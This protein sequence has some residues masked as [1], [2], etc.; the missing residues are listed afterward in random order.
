[1][2]AAFISQNPKRIVL[3]AFLFAVVATGLSL[4]AFAQGGF[5]Y[6]FPGITTNNDLTIGNINSVP[7]TATINFYDTAGKLNTLAVDLGPGTQTRVNPNTVALTTFNGSVVVTSPVPLAVSADQFEGNSPFEFFYPSELSA[8]LLIPFLPG[9]TASVDVNVFNPGPNQAEVKVVLV[10]SNGQHGTSR[11]ATL[12]P[13]HTTTINVSASANVA[14]AYVTTANIL[15]PISPVAASAVIRN[16]STGTAGAPGAVQ[17]TDFAVVP[18]IPNQGFSKTTQIPFFAQGPDYFSLVQ[19]DNLSSVQQTIS[20][21][22][23]QADGTPLPG[24]NNPASIV[25]PGYGSIRQEMAQMFG[26]TATG[27]A[28]G[29]ITATSQ[30]T[31]DIHG[32]PTGG[33]PALITTAIAIGNLSEGSLAVLLP[34]TPQTNFTL[35]LRG[36]GREFFTG[37]SILNP[38]TNDAHLSLTFI[39][40]QGT[41]SSNVSLTVPRGRE[42]IG[43]LS[44]LF[45]EAVGNGYILVRS[46]VPINLVGLDG[47]SDNSALATRAPSYAATSFSPAPQQNYLIVGTVRDTS[48]GING[49][50]IG[51]PNVAF[52]LSGPIDTTT[53]T[54][55]A[56]TFLFRDLPP[57]RYTLTPLP[58]GF[59]VNPGPRTIV[60]TNTNSHVNDFAIGLIPPGI[61]TV[62][63]ASAQLVSSTPGSNPNLPV[64]VQG[65]NFIDPTTFTGNIFTGNINKFTTGSVFVFADS[66]VPTTVSSPTLLTASVPPSLLV[67][68]GTVQ[69]RVRN[70]GPSGDFADSVSVPFTIGTAPPLLT[71]VTGVPN[72][73]IAGH[74]PGQFTV[75]VNGSGFTPATRVRVNF[76]DR[77]TTYVNQNQVMGTVLPSDLTIP[78]FVPITVQ[79]P[80]TV[81]SVAY[82][83]PL[84]Y[85]IPVISKISPTSIAA[86]VTLTAQ[87]VAVT[88]TGTDFSQS[89][90]NPL[91]TAIVLVNGARVETQYISTTQV[92]GL[93]PPTVVSVPGVLQVAVMNPQPNLAA[94]NA[95]ALFVNNPIPVIT[96]ID[97]G[98]VAF[99][100]NSPPNDFFNQQV[101]V[102]GRDFSPDAVAWFNPPCDSLGLRKALATVRNS[103]TQIV[104]TIPIRCAGKFTISVANPQPGGGL[105][106]PAT[107]NVPTVGSAVTPNVIINPQLIFTPFAGPVSGTVPTTDSAPAADAAPAREEGASGTDST[108]ADKKSRPAPG[109]R[110]D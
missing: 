3:R 82:Q 52:S 77:P 56:G 66:Q 108:E 76:V 91:D 109:A 75:T 80:N 24:T 68:T 74:V 59:N 101:V 46:D 87:P 15:R 4:S 30:G 65:S 48:V 92:I 10:Q 97:A 104:A 96:A 55:A 81:D 54:D 12:D 1:M 53:A 17:R 36:T 8:S 23:T 88:I 78:G 2:T 11:T 60:I 45:P 44:D 98:S 102:T 63:P 47:R 64:T 26:S 34:N 32:N 43:A 9:D 99:N 38:N 94:S 71:S 33:P 51:V 50:N 107:L 21:T 31:L 16:F 27:F 13:L 57:G 42:T 18:A 49:T 40:D 7:T 83:L 73:L 58:V 35:Q 29:T 20:V 5:S 86:D 61:L 72:P 90:T 70:L 85:P 19:I 41:T 37:L 93:I 22:A 6:I 39:L 103:S 62:N 25:L 89:P 84:L 105:S 14:Y 67:T 28:T 95:A 110:V 69:V 106:A 100:P 79:N